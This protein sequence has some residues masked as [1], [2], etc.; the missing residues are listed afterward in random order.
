MDLKLK[1]K[2][3]LV[4]GAS[5]GL[6]KAIAMGLAAE[7][8]QVAI[9]ARRKEL[10]ENVSNEIVSAVGMKPVIIVA[11]LYPDNASEDIAA[12]ALKA[13]G[14]VDI[15]VNSAGGTA[16]GRPQGSVAGRHHLEDL[17]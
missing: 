6:G 17:S 15:V 8:V 12:A 10:L 1:G 14:R 9:T 5:Q 11:D 16:A 3:A 13:M 4:T 2:T 7:G